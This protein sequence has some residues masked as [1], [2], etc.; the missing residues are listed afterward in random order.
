MKFEIY[1]I[2]NRIAI[3]TIKNKYCKITH[4]RIDEEKRTIKKMR[5]NN[6][7]IIFI[8]EKVKVIL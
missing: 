5:K 1:T 2:G 7:E 4:L 8:D 6:W 3:K